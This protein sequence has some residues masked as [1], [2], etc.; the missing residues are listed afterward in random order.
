MPTFPCP[1]GHISFDSDYCSECGARIVGYSGLEDSA[2][3]GINLAEN[4]NKHLEICPECTADHDPSGGNF[5]EICGY[6]FLTKA[7]GELPILTTIENP[8]FSWEVLIMV[9]STPHDPLS[10]P[11]PTNQLPISIKLSKPVNLI[12]RTSKV[13]A[14]FPEIPLDFDDAVSSRHALLL[15]Q[16]DGTLL[17]RDIGSSNGTTFKG[18]EL[19]PMTDIPLQDGDEFTLGHWCRILTRCSLKND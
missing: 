1:K 16:P 11:S 12:G 7:R 17:L 19:K 3:Q 2:N 14:I 18:I 10:P 5:C 6:N 15:C 9:D 13:R 8:Q 4:T